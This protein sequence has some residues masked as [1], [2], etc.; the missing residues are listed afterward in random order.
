MDKEQI[1]EEL[2]SL[3][4]CQ[5]PQWPDGLVNDLC[6]AVVNYFEQEEA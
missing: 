3:G 4:M 6:D 5:S 2:I 1:L